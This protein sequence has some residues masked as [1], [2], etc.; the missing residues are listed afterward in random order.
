MKLKAILL[1]FV[2]FAFF[3]LL[4]MLFFFL[5]SPVVF[6]SLLVLGILVKGGIFARLF[7]GKKETRPQNEAV[8]IEVE[9]IKM[10]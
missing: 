8:V 2:V 6:L 10:D 4:F 1:I 5:F 3:K 9:P 7:Y